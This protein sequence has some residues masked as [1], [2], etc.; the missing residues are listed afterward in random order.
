ML[1]AVPAD[2]DG[3]LPG[4]PRPGRTLWVALTQQTGAGAPDRAGG[5]R[6]RRRFTARI[7]PSAEGHGVTP[8]E[9][10]FDL[11]FVFAITQAAHH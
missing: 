9:L 4:Q 11:V 1:A 8:I 6:A 3:V 10:L 2:D 7:V 5:K